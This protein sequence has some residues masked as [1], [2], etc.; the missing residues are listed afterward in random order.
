MKTYQ[1]FLTIL[2]VTMLSFGLLACTPGKTSVEIVK[3]DL[4]QSSQPTAASEINS[5]Q[6]QIAD[7]NTIISCDKIIPPDEASLLLNQLSATLTEQ[8]AS[9]ETICTWNYTSKNGNSG[10]LQIQV[11]FGSSSVTTWEDL[12]KAEILMQPSDLDIIQISGLGDENYVWTSK[13]DNQQVVYVRQGTKTLILHFQSSEVLYMGNESG[14]IDIANR[15]F[16][17]LGI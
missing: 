12:R 3:T 1:N 13:P 2:T 6:E 5:G 15:V 14:I 16:D 17:R 8:S 7:S 10:V 4:D 11:D 9:N